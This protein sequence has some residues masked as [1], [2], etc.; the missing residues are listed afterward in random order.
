[1]YVPYYLLTLES[2]YKYRTQNGEYKQAKT[3]KQ[4]QQTNKQT[5]KVYLYTKH[6]LQNPG[7]DEN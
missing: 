2:I 4:K 7:S 5:K 1:M 3:N 6:E